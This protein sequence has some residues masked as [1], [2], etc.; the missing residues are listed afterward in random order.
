MGTVT[1][2]ALLLLF[3]VLAAATGAALAAVRRP[4]AKLPSGIQQFAAGVVFAAVAGEILPDLA[5]QGRLPAVVLG[6]TVGVSLLL[7]LRAYGRRVEA[8]NEDPK[9]QAGGRLPL[10]LLVAV[11]IDLLI[12]GLLVGHGVT[13][14]ATQ[15]SHVRVLAPRSESRLDVGPLL[16]SGRP[17]G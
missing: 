12:D 11:G 1:H 4:G 5:R 8:A 7:A 3:P 10:A 13:L 2:A 6:L 16:G 17:G 15:A 9:A 14:G